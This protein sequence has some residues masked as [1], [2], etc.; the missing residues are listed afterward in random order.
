[1]NI[2]I[3]EQL[4]LVGFDNLDISAHL[5][6]P[7]TTVAQPAFDIGCTAGELLLGQIDKETSWIQRRI[8]PVQ[9][10][11]RQSCGAIKAISQR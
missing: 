9:L 10:I 2:S 11:V 3:P 6:I 7:L 1:L 4:A 5:D 8:M